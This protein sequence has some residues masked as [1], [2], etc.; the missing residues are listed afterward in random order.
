MTQLDVGGD[1]S[2]LGAGGHAGPARLASMLGGDAAPKVQA[3]K[4]SWE[5]LT[6][7][8]KRFRTRRSM[9]V[10]LLGFHWGVI[11]RPDRPPLQYCRQWLPFHSSAFWLVEAGS[12]P[13]EK[14]KIIRAS[15]RDGFRMDTD[16]RLSSYQGRVRY[17]K[18]EGDPDGASSDR[19]TFEL[20]TP[21]QT[22]RDTSSYRVS[23][24]QAR[25]IEGDYLDLTYNH[26]PYGIVLTNSAIGNYMNQPAEV[27]GTLLGEPVS[28]LG[29]FDRAYG[30][31]SRSS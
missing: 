21:A 18:V 14:P 29:A 6:I 19:F 20:R 9:P 11:E 12:T 15:G 5:D 26:M 23:S 7:A 3:V 31:P 27:T 16:S 10:Q 30:V 17:R 1:A 2:R 4:L 22:R 24:V 28:F 8:P 25:Q 13:F